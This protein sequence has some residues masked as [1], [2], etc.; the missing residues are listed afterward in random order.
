MVNKCVCI[1]IP[2]EFIGSDKI[3]I[4]NIYRY[5]EFKKLKP[6]DRYLIIDDSNKDVLE[7]PFHWFGICFEPITEYR[8]KKINKIL[9]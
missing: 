2:K 9:K 7:V 8:N 3:K 5:V 1:N 4:G 6:K